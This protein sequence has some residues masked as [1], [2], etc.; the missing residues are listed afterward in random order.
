MKKS[1]RAAASPS[2]VSFAN[3]L[4]GLLFPLNDVLVLPL[5]AVCPQCCCPVPALS[6]L[7]LNS[8]LQDI[9]FLS[10][11]FR[12]G[13]VRGAGRS[14]GSSVLEGIQR[15]QCMWGGWVHEDRKCHKIFSKTTR[16]E[17]AAPHKLY[18][19]TSVLYPIWDCTCRGGICSLQHSFTNWACQQSVMK[20]NKPPGCSVLRGA[21]PNLFVALRQTQAWKGSGKDMVRIEMR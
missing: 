21:T 19:L 15:Q 18:S 5:L 14:R 1:P 9:C 8:L 11:H 3:I 20:P 4:S 12:E 2:G 10:H 16:S 17:K 7:P 13:Q 6:P